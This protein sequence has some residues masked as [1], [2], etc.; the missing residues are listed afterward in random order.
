MLRSKAW[1]VY[2]FLLAACLPEN[3]ALSGT[4]F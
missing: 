1:S 3:L 4:F 2:V